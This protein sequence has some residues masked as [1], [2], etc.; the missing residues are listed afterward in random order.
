MF[1]EKEIKEALLKAGLSENLA[2]KITVDKVDDIEGAVTV[3]KED[4]NKVKNLT[5]E[6]F[7]KSLKDAGL[8]DAYERVLKSETDRRVT[9]ALETNKEKLAREA[10]EA[11]ENK[12]KAAAKE[13]DQSNMTADQKRFVTLE[14]RIEKLTTSMEGFTSKLTAQ[15]LES[16]KLSALKEA[17]LEEEHISYVKGDNPEQIAEEVSK[18]KANMDTYRQD[19]IDKKLV[20][21]DLALGKVGIA[22]KTASESAVIDYA[23]SKNKNQL[24]TGLAS[25]QVEKII[26][27]K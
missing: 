18:L 21:G 26:Q 2:D 16:V 6:E 12:K 22:G 10:S 15:S 24:G 3:L 9:Q 1:F 8:D 23:K 19:G 25:E 17:G 7:L 11:A 14:D 5:N 13:K 4:M 20:A 27:D